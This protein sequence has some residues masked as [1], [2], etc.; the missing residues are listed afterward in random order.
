MQF[1]SKTSF[2]SGKIH[3][4]IKYLDNCQA[5]DHGGEWQLETSNVSAHAPLQECL[6][7]VFHLIGFYAMGITNDERSFGNNKNLLLA[8]VKPNRFTVPFIRCSVYSAIS[9]S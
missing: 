1:I 8:W 5:F 7:L 2:L 9:M 4:V 3:K 6:L